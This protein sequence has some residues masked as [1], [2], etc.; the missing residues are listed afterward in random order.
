MSSIYLD[1]KFGRLL[2]IKPADLLALATRIRRD[3]LHTATSD[4]RLVK[5]T[6]GSFN[7]VHIIEFQDEFRMVIRVPIMGKSGNLQG[8]AKQAFE[9][10]VE[11]MRYVRATTTIPVP[12]VYHFDTTADN[13]ISAPYIAMACIPGGTMF[14]V[15]FDNSDERREERRLRI[16]SQLAGFMFQLRGL[17]FDRIGSLVPATETAAI[18]PCFDWL[19]LRLDKRHLT[20]VVDPDKDPTAETHQLTS[21]GPFVTTESWL[22]QIWAPTDELDTYNA[23]CVKILQAM[24]RHVPAPSTYDYTL[25]VP[26]LGLGNVMADDLGNITALIDWDNA[27][28]TLGFLGPLAMYPSWLTRDW[29]PLLYL[30][31]DSERE[32]SPEQL[33]R[34]RAY[35]RSEIKTL[36][37]VAGCH[38]CRFIEKG[39][40]FEAFRIAL[41]DDICRTAICQKFIEE[42]IRMLRDGESA[43][44]DASGL[45]I[46]DCGPLRVKALFGKVLRCF[47]MQSGKGPDDLL[48][49]DGLGVLLDVGDGYMEYEDW[50]ELEK[51]LE[52]LMSLV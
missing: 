8:I 38:D 1:K 29:N 4:S 7:L 41:E 24:Q 5:T 19:G 52:M 13:E 14:S 6:S 42:A 31:P 39:H 30:W 26:D 36:L 9:S 20:G 18:G 17:R 50:M 46:V 44:D 3:V 48:T 51:G 11:T 12:E 37:E 27:H 2:D 32:D 49:M 47:G 21:Y 33:A 15:W 16:L 34:Y 43:D 40:V 28:T 35:Y 22:Q 10:Q 23:A 25:M 45:D